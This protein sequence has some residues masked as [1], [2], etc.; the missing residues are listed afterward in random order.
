MITMP[1]IGSLLTLRDKNL[2][3]TMDSLAKIDNQILHKIELLAKEHAPDLDQ[4]IKDHVVQK[5]LF[6][7]DQSDESS[8]KQSSSKTSNK[9]SLLLQSQHYGQNPNLYDPMKGPT[10]D[11]EPEMRQIDQR[12]GDQGV[13]CITEEEEEDTMAFLLIEN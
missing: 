12:D 8:Q 5:I 10:N 4:N 1:V 11:F 2:N 9:S 3:A 6:G 13:I 7:V